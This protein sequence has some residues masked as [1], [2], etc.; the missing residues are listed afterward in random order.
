VKQLVAILVSSVYAFGF[1]W[2]M[3]WLINKFTPVRTS[4]TEEGL[5]DES[6]HGETAYETNTL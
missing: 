4:E 1:T 3:L 2:G 6:L 5:L